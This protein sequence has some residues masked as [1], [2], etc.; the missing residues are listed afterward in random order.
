[1]FHEENPEVPEESED[2]R[3][4]E[5]EEYRP[6]PANFLDS[7]YFCHFQTSKHWGE[8]FLADWNLFRIFSDL[9]HHE[10]SRSLADNPCSG[11]DN[12]DN[13]DGDVLQVV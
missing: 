12:K 13:G 3:G 2:L 10:E 8:M 4:D 6:E 1:M 5:A 11:D 9:I 7:T